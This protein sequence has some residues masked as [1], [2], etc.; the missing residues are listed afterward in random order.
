VDWSPVVAVASWRDAWSPVV[1]VAVVSADWLP[2]VAALSIVTLDRPR[3]SIV[4]LTLDVDPVTEVS[5]LAL[6][7]SSD[8]P[9]ELDGPANEGLALAPLLMPVE[10][11][12]AADGELVPEASVPRL[13][14]VVALLSLPTEAVESG[15]Q[16]RWTGLAER[17][18]AMPVSLPAS[19]PALAWSSSLQRGLEA[20]ALADAVT[21][22]LVA[23]PVVSVAVV[24][25]VVLGFAVAFVDAL[26]AVGSPTCAQAGAVPSRAARVM[27]LR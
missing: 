5:W 12:P 1:V 6:E 14:A 8:E 27:V 17:S 26:S 3:R 10:E 16:S 7:P 11:E 24:S 18:P 9:W 25:A 15:M 23:R 19:L 21:P 4:G 13:P 2:V 22:G 20:V